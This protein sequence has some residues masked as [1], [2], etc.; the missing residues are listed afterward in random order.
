[1]I[2]AKLIQM[3]K[4]APADVAEA[5][6]GFLEESRSIGTV[7]DLDYLYVKLR[8]T[9]AEDLIKEVEE[10][11]K[12]D[13]LPEQSEL[14]VPLATQHQNPENVFLSAD[15]SIVN[16]SQA[17]LEAV[18]ST[19]KVVDEEAIKKAVNEAKKEAQVKLKKEHFKLVRL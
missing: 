4:N 19:V 15:D 10:E 5:Y 11:E 16:P 14:E 8:G 12:S 17:P 6:K 9:S 2:Q 18:A 13:T 1:M 7:Q 3:I